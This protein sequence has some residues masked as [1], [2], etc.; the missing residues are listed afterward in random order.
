[1]A[2]FG[3]E[4][5]HGVDVRDRPLRCLVC[6]HNTFYRRQAQMH[7]Q[8]AT[9]FNVEWSAPTCD[10]VVCSQCGYVHSFFPMKG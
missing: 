4:K 2:I 6:Q 1:M 8:L 10:C 3:E 5:P 9:I 7:G